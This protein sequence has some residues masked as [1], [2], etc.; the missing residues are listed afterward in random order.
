VA[1]QPIQWPTYFREQACPDSLA[2]Y[3]SKE[4]LMEVLGE[5]HD[6][7]EEFEAWDAEARRLRFELEASFEAKTRRR[8]VYSIPSDC[9]RLHVE[10]LDREGLVEAMT[11]YGA[12]RGLDVD[13]IADE[14]PREYWRR[15]KRAEA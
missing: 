4:E 6:I 14:T 15:L 8:R 9:V 2:T 7:L 3:D 12:A 11:A 10:G 13:W 1:N 5:F